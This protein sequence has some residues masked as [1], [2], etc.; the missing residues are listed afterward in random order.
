VPK[1]AIIG[2]DCFE[3]SL[4]FHR[5]RDQLPNLSRLMEQGAWGRLES[6]IPP[7]TVP[8]WTAMMSSKNPGSLGFYGFRNRADYTYDGMM[9]ATSD[10]V[11][12]D[13]AWEILSREGK[14]VIVMGVPQ[15][16]PPRQVNGQMVTSFLTPSKQ[17]PYTWPPELRDEI[18]EVVPDYVLDV[19]EFRTD[20]KLGLLERVYDMT[21]QRF[22]LARHL[23][24]TKPWDFFM[25]VAMG[26]DRL[27][28]GFWRYFDPEH[29]KHVP[30][31]K[32]ANVGLKYYQFID[33]QIGQLIDLMDDDTMVMVVSDHGAQRMEGGLCVNEWLIREGYLTLKEMPSEP[34]SINKLDIDWSRTKAWG[35]GGYYARLFMNVQG[36]EPQGVIPAN[37]YESARDELVAKLEA[38]VDPVGR[39][40]GTVAHKP[41]EV[42]RQVKGIAPDLIV[43]FGNLAWR[44]VGSVGY[45]DVY[46]F[47]NDTGPDDANHGQ[48]GIYVA[49]GRLGAARGELAGLHIT[50]IAPTVLSAFGLPIPNDMEGKVIA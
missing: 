23:I 38:I 49:R 50:D 16:Y 12:D 37:E 29:P 9:I 30:G 21:T 27:H 15:T 2:L 1:L 14:R 24:S 17:S 8:A 41:E 18:D 31:N 28:H 36:R 4:V 48:H 32:F 20:D 11:K 22:A 33:A 44:S 3:P 42:Y 25:M 13:L 26:P 35:S 6:T 10:A 47:E 46:T 34:T 39:N 19:K 45:D 43:Y 40:I 5:W 7:I